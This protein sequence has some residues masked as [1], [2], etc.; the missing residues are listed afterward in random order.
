MYAITTKMANIMMTIMC[1]GMP[2]KWENYFI[3]VMP[4]IV[5]MIPKI[6]QVIAILSLRDLMIPTIP[7]PN[8]ISPTI[9]EYF[10]SKFN[11]KNKLLSQNIIQSV[12]S[13]MNRESYI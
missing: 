12:Y 8:I 13:N 6:I 7:I 10:I 11:N 5:I 3:C 2:N 1:I 9:I 4:V